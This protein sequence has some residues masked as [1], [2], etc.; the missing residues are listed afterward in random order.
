M[1]KNATEINDYIFKKIERVYYE[2]WCCFDKKDEYI[3][4]IMIDI[5]F[6]VYSPKV[7]CVIKLPNDSNVQ[8]YVKIN[9]NNVKK[10]FSPPSF[11]AQKH[12]GMMK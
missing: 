7:S 5:P 12:S 11:G 1:M 8:F 2:E 9:N 3:G 10:E 4:R 6:D